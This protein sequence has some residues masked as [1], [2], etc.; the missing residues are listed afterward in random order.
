MILDLIGYLLVA[1]GPWRLTTNC[2]H[3]FGRWCVSHAGGW[4]YRQEPRSG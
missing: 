3:A 1:Y 2:S 4:D